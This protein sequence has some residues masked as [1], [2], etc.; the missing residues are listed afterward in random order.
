VPSRRVLILSV[1]LCAGWAWSAAG[2]ARFARGTWQGVA[3]PAAGAAP[4]VPA[5][6][7]QDAAQKEARIKR[8]APTPPAVGQA[9]QTEDVRGAAMAAEEAPA[10]AGAAP[11]ESA[12]KTPPPPGS[13]EPAPAAPRKSAPA[14]KSAPA[15]KPAPAEKAAPAEEPASEGSAAPEEE[16]SPAKEPEPPQ[17][18]APVAEPAPDQ[19]PARAE[20]RA[21]A[22]PAPPAT[23]APPAKAAPVKSAAP[24]KKIT[25]AKGGAPAKGAAADAVVVENELDKPRPPAQE[26][27]VVPVPAKGAAAAAVAAEAET[28]GDAKPGTRKGSLEIPEED[29]P[30]VPR[31][32]S[33]VG[34]AGKI[35]KGAIDVT[36]FLEFL[37]L[38][39]DKPVIYDSVNSATYF[40]QK[41]I[42]LESDIPVLTY[43]IA[44]AILDVN[45]FS[46][47]ERTLPDG[48]KIIEVQASK[49][50]QARTEGTPIIDL[51]DQRKP[52]QAFDPDETATFLVPLKHADTREAQNVLNQIFGAAAGGKPGGGIQVVPVERTNTLFV[53]AKYGLIGYLWSI[54]QKFDIP[55]PEAEQIIEIIDVREA[56]VVELARLIEDVLRE[57]NRDTTQRAGQAG[58]APATTT[59]SLIR[60]RTTSSA[61]RLGGASS[62]RS[63]S[64]SY[65]SYDFQTA[66][67]PEER[68]MKIIV[69]TTSEYELE[70][71][72]MLVEELDTEMTAAR[73]KTHIYQVKYLTAPDVADVLSSLIEGTRRTGGLTGRTSGTRAA[74]TRRTSTLRSA[75][76]TPGATPT[77]AGGAT[78]TA[79]GVTSGETRI[80]PHEQTNSLLIQA[81]P[82]EFEEILFILNT[83]D[84]KR[85]QVFLESALVQVSEKSDLNYT[86]ELLAGSLDNKNLSAAA[87]SS[88]GL[89]T[90]DPTL[91]PD[92]FDRLLLEKAPTSGLVGAVAKNGQ[93]PA[94]IRFFKQDNESQVLA[95]PFILAD[96]NEPNEINVTT[97]TYVLSTSSL[98]NQTTVS[99]PKGEEAGVRLLLTPTIS[100]QAVLLDMT[101][102]VS[103]F[104]ES[105][106][107]SGN[108]PDKTTNL[109]QGKVSV[110]D[111]ELFVVGGLT[112]ETSSRAVDKLPILGDLPLIGFLFQS[113]S[114]SKKRSNLY[115]FLTA[116]VLTDKDFRDAG[117]LTR[118][119]EQSMRDFKEGKTIKIERWDPPPKFEDRRLEDDASDTFTP[120]RRQYRARKD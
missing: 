30:V 77:T 65:G 118:Q 101:L 76:T 23:K 71:V 84:R 68:T 49:V 13:G 74:T 48:A 22:Q 21:P 32:K 28:E 91:L 2:E 108:L 11:S 31:D 54:V 61:S 44:K 35:I 104:A 40:S 116:F 92:T 63:R 4:S 16:S 7:P 60:T 34:K 67:I 12:A 50:I 83:I 107:V 39:Q 57:S 102:E 64:S 66:L 89:S 10:A 81:D 53:K 27:V 55:L 17:K 56:E 106:T 62:Y 79:G 37:A 94:L 100:R 3:M 73:R 96:D 38:N 113:K 29:E 78:G 45:G 15:E 9:A 8:A 110:P 14:K 111:G 97:T 52:P 70:L 6:A 5:A 18:V 98:A 115:V 19:E 93:L 103:Q 95:T 42:V 33:T 51:E 114:T 47:F 80:V 99:E 86:I 25:D 46:V 26:S 75:T 41:V 85:N 43:E 59:S 88:F 120:I 109:I 105:A 69:V 20:E 24:A 87:M 117:D 72:R 1:W 36:R 58:A 112:S 90:L 82:D 119:A